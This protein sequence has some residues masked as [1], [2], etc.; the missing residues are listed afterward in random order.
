[1]KKALWSLHIGECNYIGP[2]RNMWGVSRSRGTLLG[3]P[4]NEDYSILGSILWVPLFGQTTILTYR[5]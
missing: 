3:V 2:L 4:K 5:K 1:M